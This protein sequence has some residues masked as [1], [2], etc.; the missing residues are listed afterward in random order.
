MNR[1]HLSFL[2][3]ILVKTVCAQ[4]EQTGRIETPVRID[5]EAFSIV[6]LDTAGLLLYRNFVGSAENQTEL[7]RLDTS[8]QQKWRGFL[9]TP[10]TLQLKSVKSFANKIYFFFKNLIPGSQE[11]IVYTVNIKGGSYRS[12]TIKNVIQFNPTEYVVATN[13][14][15]IGGY[16]N[17]R[18]LVLFFSL[19]EEK[20]HLLPGFLNEPGEI[21]QIESYPDGTSSVVTSAKNING[22]KCIWI[23]HFDSDGEFLKT[24]IIEPEDNKNLIFGRVAKTDNN[25]Q[26]VAGV[27]GRNSYFSRGL[28]VA[29]INEYGEYAVHYYNFGDLENFFHYMKAKREKRIKDRIERRHIKGKKIKFN[30]RFLVHEL[31]TDGD[32]FILTGEAFYP[33]YAGR[34]SYPNLSPY[35]S[36]SPWG[37]GPNARY[38]PP[39]YNR[40]NDLVFDGFQYTHAVAIGFDKNGTLKW[41]NSFEIN[42]IKT[43]E[44]E[45]YVKIV[46]RQNHIVL[47]YLYENLIR[48]KIIKDNQVIEGTTQNPVKTFNGQEQEAHGIRSNKLEHWF[49]NHFFAYGIQNLKDAEI[50]NQTRTVFFINKLSVR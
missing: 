25:S 34:S 43:F 39:T 44:L 49:G 1:V 22:K 2:F 32:Q 7:I 42:G 23:R 9:P 35:N 12:Y 40:P 3:L 6:S 27:Y 10:K 21:T 14:I 46:P 47:L 15:L 17:F 26:V 13:A 33:K 11:F 41:D 48:S 28:F 24:T 8:L 5:A 29:E 36:T 4:V 31:I 30:Y 16:F 20:S 19:K 45:Q 50:P 37:Y 18:P 38:Y